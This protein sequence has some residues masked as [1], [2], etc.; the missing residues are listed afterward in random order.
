M[1]IA[2]GS[3]AFFRTQWT[4]RF[5][6]TCTIN[7]RA[8]GTLNTT[9]GIIAAGADA[10][11]YSGACL[12]RPATRQNTR[13]VELGG[14]DVAITMYEVHVPYSTD[15]IEPR[16]QVVLDTVTYDSDLQGQTLRVLA[17]TG[18]SYNTHRTLLCG[19]NTGGGS[20]A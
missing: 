6:D 4:N 14:E 5:I 11:Q 15:G 1:S 8:A 17:V 10:E 18:D 20:S 2:S 19:L 3:V 7:R 13:G 9:T 16:D 12:V